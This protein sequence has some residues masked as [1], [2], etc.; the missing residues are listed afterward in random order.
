MKKLVFILLMVVLIVIL[1]NNVGFIS[2]FINLIDIVIN[3]NAFIFFTLGMSIIL[4][5]DRIKKIIEHIKSKYK[6]SKVKYIE[7]KR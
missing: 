1:N 4:F 6:E 5:E 3:S 7:T 2:R